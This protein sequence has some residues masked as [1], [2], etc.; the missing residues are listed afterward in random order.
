VNRGL[1]LEVRQRLI[2]PDQLIFD[3]TK[4]EHSRRSNSQNSSHPY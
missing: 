2:P 4:V 1:F 3:I